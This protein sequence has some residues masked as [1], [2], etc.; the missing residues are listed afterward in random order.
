M[1]IRDIEGLKLPKK[2]DEEF[3]N[4]DFEPLFNKEFKEVEKLDIKNLENSDVINFYNCPL[5]EISKKLDGT[6][7]SFIIDKDTDKPLMLVHVLDADD[8][9]L[10]NALNIHI[11]K[12]VKARIVD[13]VVD[14]CVDSAMSANRTITLEDDARLEYLKLQEVS[15]KNSLLYNVQINQGKNSSVDIINID[16]GKGFGVNT[17]INEI[18]NENATYKLSGFSKIMDNAKCSNLIKTTHNAKNSTSD[19]IYKHTLKDR[20]Y[21]VF[22]A[23]SIVNKEALF[24]KAFQNCH[25][26]SLSDEAVIFA[27]PHL[28]IF[29]DELEASHGATT[30][31]LDKDGLLYLQSR[32]ISEQKAHEMLLVAF[33]KEVIEA[34]KDEKLK[35]VARRYTKAD[36]V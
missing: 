20:G 17:F 5:F 31:G 27:Q 28:E 12:G 6:Q 4:I 15:E 21:G 9:F 34:I 36:Y 23:T 24:T 11:K 16:Y 19:I 18:N 14:D 22:K 26:V 7:K 2:G 29:I 10:I 33:E 35:D 3:L 30:G 13:I 32:G 1:R 8:I 25:N